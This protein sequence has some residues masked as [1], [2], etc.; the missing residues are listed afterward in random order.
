MKWNNTDF[1]TYGIVVDSFPIIPRG[2]HNF[3]TYT[4]TGRN[5]YISFDEETYQSFIIQVN[6]HFDPNRTTKT[7]SEARAFL[8]GY[9][10]LEIESGKYYNA[11]VY[12]TLDFAK[13]G[14]TNFK[15]FSVQFAC[16]PLAHN[17]Q[18]TTLTYTT[19]PQTFTVGGTAPTKPVIT[20]QGVGD[21]Q[22]Y[23]NGKYFVLYGMVSGETYTLDCEAMTIKDHDG[24][25]CS[26]M[27]RYGFPELKAGSNTL[28]VTTSV[29][30]ITDDDNN[31]IV[32]DNNEIMTVSMG[33][34]I[35]SMSI[36]YKEAY[37]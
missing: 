12:G 2:E 27:M 14:R 32:A 25:N 19:F 18:S 16:Q 31:V 1:I 6:C 15:S 17:T 4:T 36:T 37:L 34:G 3:T 23:F 24:D 28:N 35:T 7:Y 9:G 5:G 20:I 21:N 26:N 33:N 10:A 11:Y 29:V 13:M 30:A 8:D 22:I